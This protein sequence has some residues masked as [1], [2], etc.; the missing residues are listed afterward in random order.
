M[1]L[2]EI[3]ARAR[4]RVREGFRAARCY[5]GVSDAQGTRWEVKGNAGFCGIGLALMGLPAAP[6]PA[7]GLDER[8]AATLG[9]TLDELFAF[10]MGFDR[11]PRMPL[12]D[13]DEWKRAGLELALE[14][15]RGD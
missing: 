6:N 7:A 3:T 10:Q 15:V 12:D 9:I 13:A 4:A 8:A 5:L 1:L 14:L 2:S 11:D